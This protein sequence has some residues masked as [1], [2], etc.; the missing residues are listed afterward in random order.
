MNGADTAI[1]WANLICCLVAV[2][3]NMWASTRRGGWSEWRPLRLA[4][5]LLAVVYATG[6]ALLLAGTVD[7]RSW[8]AFYRGVSPVAWLVVWAGPAV[9]STHVW[10][11]FSRG[12]SEHV[13]DEMDR[14]GRRG[15]H[16]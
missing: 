2:T 5:A 11:R 14:V 15:D 3:A 4:V 10:R 12:L 9:W 13:R 1:I 16:S 7:L 8:S 6:Y